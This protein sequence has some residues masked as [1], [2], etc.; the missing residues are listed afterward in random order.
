LLTRNKFGSKFYNQTLYKFLKF[1]FLSFAKNIISPKKIITNK[2]Y[3]QLG[4]GPSDVKKKFINLDFNS[5]SKKNIIFSDFR[6]PLRFDNNFFYGAFSE[7]TLEHL[8]SF[9]ALKFLTEVYRILR[10]GSVFRIVV[11]DLDMY[12][13]YYNKKFSNK[14]FKNFANGCEA[15]WNI[16][17]NYGHLS[18][19]NYEMLRFQL[20]DIGFRKVYK[21]KFKYGINK[22]LLIDKEGRQLESMYVEAIK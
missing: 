12:V 5:N 17:S 1:E 8:N 10:I 11:P 19:W 14:H 18:V 2:K 16:S 9:N 6:Y 13:K 7:H 4:C 3:I 21:A 22:N 15:I 20:K